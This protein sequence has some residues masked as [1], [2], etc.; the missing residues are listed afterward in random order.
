MLCAVIITA[1]TA[2]VVALSR[3][4]YWVSEHFVEVGFVDV[5]TL[6]RSLSNRTSWSRLV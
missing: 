2:S 5:A 4:S 6:A 3:P 1:T